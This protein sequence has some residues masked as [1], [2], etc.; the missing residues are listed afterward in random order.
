M[1][2]K[3]IIVI[4][5]VVLALAVCKPVYAADTVISEEGQ[6]SVPV[7]YTAA[8]TAYMIRI[9][10]FIS[11][12][13]NIEEYSIGA[14]N[15]NL[16]PD[17]CVKVYITEG[18]DTTGAVTL[19]RQNV[20]AGKKAATLNTTFMI[21]DKNIKV[22]DNGYVV[23][24]FKDGAN[25]TKNMTGSILVTPLNITSN[26]EAGDYMGTVTFSIKLESL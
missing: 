2:K 13:G 5:S 23:G 4:M 1:F 25:S 12:G 6:V 22:S 15:V 8:T 17:E 18:C 20:P 3:F 19:T 21:K 24:Y 11:A 9:P 16:R 10:A 7:K 14:D 26:T